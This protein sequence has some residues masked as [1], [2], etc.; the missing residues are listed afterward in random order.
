MAES[1][2]LADDEI[3]GECDPMEALLAKH[4]KEKK[5]LK[6]KTLSMKKTA[7][8]GNKQKQKETNAEIERLE[9]EMTARH[10]KEIADLK[11]C[12]WLYAYALLKNQSF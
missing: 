9:A 2:N 3:E 5:S 1:T 11:V 7:K 12:A 8:S 6:E 10:E 4:R